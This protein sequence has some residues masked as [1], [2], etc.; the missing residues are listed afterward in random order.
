MEME[1]KRH[2]FISLGRCWNPLVL[3]DAQE[4]V[5]EFAVGINKL[6]VCRVITQG[7]GYLEILPIKNNPTNK[8]K[9]PKKQARTTL[10]LHPSPLFSHLSHG[11]PAAFLQ[12]TA[13][14][15]GGERQQSKHTCPRATMHCG[16]SLWLCSSCRDVKAKLSN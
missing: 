10:R 3:C 16:F 6:T 11:M 9:P 8:A 5:R 2:H 7:T 13:K 1:H 15:R 12:E 4:G 14:T